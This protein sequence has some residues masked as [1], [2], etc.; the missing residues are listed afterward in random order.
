M[1]NVTLWWML[2]VPIILS[3]LFVIFAPKR[4][5]GKMSTL[6]ALAFGVMGVIISMGIFAGALYGSRASATADTE[7]INGEIVDKTR[8]HGSYQRSYDCNCRKVSSCSGS[9]KNRSCS[10]STKC[11]TCYEDRYTVKWRAISTVGTFT[12]DS[13]DRSSRSVYAAPDPQ[14]YTIIQKGE[15]ACVQRSYTNYIRGVPQSILRPAAAEVKAKYAGKIPAY[16]IHVY[17]FYRV[18]RFV[19]AGLAVPEANVWNQ[20]ISEI[21]KVVGPLKQANVVVVVTSYDP[22]FFYALQDAWVNGKKND[23][24]VV[25]GQ[26]QYGG[27]AEWV[28]V[29]ALT[30]SDILQVTLRDSILELPNI[31]SNAVLPVIKGVI[32]KNYD[33]KEMK[34]FKFLEDQIDPPTW[35]IA[36][37]LGGVALA[38]ILAFLLLPQMFKERFTPSYRIRQRPRW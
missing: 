7:L 36:T 21:A 37:S 24:I 10:T 17:D 25:I 4:T 31:S 22:D 9:G 14:R 1:L 33:R 5:G 30:K 12:I 11:D 29:M 15:P 16:P 34:D 20:G 6:A 13:L 18:N 35:V 26:K 28:R 32:L 23:V 38:Y 8:E 19:A 3:I 27:P 2:V